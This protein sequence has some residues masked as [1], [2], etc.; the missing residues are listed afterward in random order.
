MQPYK[1]CFWLVVQ[2][3]YEP[4]YLSTT[5]NEIGPAIKGGRV[6][7]NY[8]V[9]ENMPYGSSHSDD[10]IPNP[11]TFEF[12][13][14]QFTKDKE[15][16]K[17][18]AYQSFRGGPRPLHLSLLRPPI[19]QILRATGF[20][21]TKP[22][23]LDTLTDLTSRYLILLATR[24]T[25]H[26]ESASAETAAAAADLH[27][28]VTVTLTS[29]RLALQDV[30]LLH[31]T[32]SEAEQHFTGQEDVRGLNGFVEWCTG[33]VNAEIRRVAG[34]GGG[35][36]GGGGDNPTNT[37]TITTTTTAGGGGVG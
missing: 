4:S 21:S 9:E 6:D 1:M 5:R 24:T 28:S 27:S 19:L 29:L 20:T 18:P 26:A 25:L 33:P 22:S 15:L 14:Q 17:K 30:G 31:P 32:R 10:K 3:I 37:I 36:G 23:V 13:P 2:T 16:T 7:I 8:L 34:M 11:N 35:D 12:D